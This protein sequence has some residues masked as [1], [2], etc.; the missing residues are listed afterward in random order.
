M[1]T[2]VHDM[3][4]GVVA[5]LNVVVTLIICVGAALALVKL[6]ASATKPARF[7]T[8]MVDARLALA[9]W[10]ALALEFAVAGDIVLMAITPTWSELGMLAALIVLRMALNYSLE[11]ELAASRSREQ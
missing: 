9:R 5:V 7:A 1:T 2:F 10:L 8:A 11:R 3:A 6:F 4:L